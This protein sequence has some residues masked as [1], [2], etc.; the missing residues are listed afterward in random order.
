M[1]NPHKKRKNHGRIE[2]SLFK[3]DEVHS[4]FTN[5]KEEGV[6]GEKDRDR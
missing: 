5:G 1:E 4:F 3:N 2:F 6:E